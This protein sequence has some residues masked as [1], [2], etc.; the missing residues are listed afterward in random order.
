MEEALYAAA[1]D[2]TSLVILGLEKFTAPDFV[3]L[4]S[5]SAPSHGPEGAL[6]RSET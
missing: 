5:L 1:P 4:E 6:M 2:A 3:P